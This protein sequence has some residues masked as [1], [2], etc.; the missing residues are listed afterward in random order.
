MTTS[1]SNYPHSLEK[2]RICPFLGLADDAQTALAFPSDWNCCHRCKPVG[3]IRL[4]HQRTYCLGPDHIHCTAYV[5]APGHTLPRDLRNR[6]PPR[7]YIGNRVWKFILASG[8]L[9]LI[10]GI[11][12]LFQAQIGAFVRA[13]FLDPLAQ[14]SSYPTSIPVYETPS[15]ESRPSSTPGLPTLAAPSTQPSTF[16]S[17]ASV[18]VPSLAA[19]V[20]PTITRMPHDMDTLIGINYIFKIHRVQHGENLELLAQRYGTTSVAIIAV[21]YH[22]T[23]PL[24]V[25]QVIVLPVNQTDVSELP[26]FEPYRVTEATT[27]ER[28]AEELGVGGDLL[29]SYNGL[30]TSDQL[31]PGEWIVVPHEK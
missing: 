31:V 29:Q 13:N 12:W 16:F 9:A 28:L 22:L 17:D 23:T 11:S 2:A 6:Y 3:S 14:P 25:Q 7:I 20:T 8:F 5:Q 1:I 27:T 18:V 26:A 15:P 30:G 4:D 21:N 10:V 24:W 19:Q